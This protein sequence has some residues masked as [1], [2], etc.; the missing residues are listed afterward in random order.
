[1]R[2]SA[3]AYT[4]DAIIDAG[5][6]PETARRIVADGPRAVPE[7]P[8]ISVRRRGRAPLTTSYIWG[9]DANA[10]LAEPAQVGSR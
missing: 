5:V 7:R 2:F 1:M 4:V 9:P 6:P 10:L 3:D 8:R